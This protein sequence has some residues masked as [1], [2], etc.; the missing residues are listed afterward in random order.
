MRDLELRGVGNLIGPEQHGRISDVGYELYCKLMAS[1]VNE[2]LGKE[3]PQKPD[4]VIE[5]PLDAHIP[6]DYIPEEIRRLEVYKRIAS[7]T[8]TEQMYDVQ[9]ELEDRFGD[10]PP[11]VQTLMDVAL[12]KADCERAGIA[13]LVYSAGNIRITF[14][15]G[16][17]LP[18]E[19]L[20]AFLNDESDA[21]IVPLDVPVIQLT[22][23]KA[24]NRDFLAK[25]ARFVH[26]LNDCIRA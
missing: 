1:A 14:M 17:S 22:C 26:K 20:I 23:K 12:L 18:S 16:A 19:R 3:T 24:I 13:S 2:A 9:E 4:T 21:R 10:I 25:T 7:I 5:L 6:Y 11:Q 15:P 8:T